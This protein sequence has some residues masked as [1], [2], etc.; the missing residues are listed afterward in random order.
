MVVVTVCVGSMGT[1]VMEAKIVSVVTVVF[2]C[3]SG[4]YFAWPGQSVTV[5]VR[6]EKMLEVD[7]VG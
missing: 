2:L 5:A 3:G 1:T 7:T 4:Q 6:V